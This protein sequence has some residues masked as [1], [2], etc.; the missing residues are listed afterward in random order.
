M[1]KYRT[2]LR[3]ARNWQEFSTARKITQDRNLTQAEALRRCKDYN[4]N[5][6]SA[7]IRRGTKMEFTSE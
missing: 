7:Q 4:D 2:F 1:A 5:R 3:S 6:T